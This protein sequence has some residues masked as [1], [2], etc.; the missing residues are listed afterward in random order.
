MSHMAS[1]VTMAARRRRHRVRARNFAEVP[2]RKGA[3]DLACVDTSDAA[4]AKALK[5]AFPAARSLVLESRATTAVEFAI[6][7][8]AMVLMVIGF[9]EFGR[10]AWTYE[11]LQTVASEG[12]R[13]MGLRAASCAAAGVYSPANTTSYVK[14]LATSR[15]VSISTATISLNNA[16][17]CGGASGFSQVAISYHFTTVVPNLLASLVHGMSVAASACFP[18]NS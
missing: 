11:V 3:G 12:A 10:L 15:G 14:S 5:R 8:M 13:C 2:P 16:M 7:S 9:V 6:C 18:N 1:S 4:G 17:T